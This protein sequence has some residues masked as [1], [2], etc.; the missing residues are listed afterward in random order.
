MKR[1]SGFVAERQSPVRKLRKPRP[2]SWC[3]QD[4]IG[5]VI[6]NLGQWFGREDMR[7]GHFRQISCMWTSGTT[8]LT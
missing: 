2:N 4:F 5:W 3:E 6:A 7:D 8:A 1:L